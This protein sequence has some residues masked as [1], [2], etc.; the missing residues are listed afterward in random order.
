VTKG[1]A[2]DARAKRPRNPQGEG[3]RLRDELIAA[4]SRL[5]EAGIDPGDL[6]LRA[7][8]KEAR[9]AAPSIYLQ[10]ENKDSLMRAVVLDH[11]ARFRQ[12]LEAE[13]ARGDDPVSRLLYGCLAYGQFAR[14]Q[15]GSFRIIFETNNAEWGDP[16]PEE[17]IG[18]DTFMIL[19]NSVAECMEIGIARTGDPFQTAI[20]IWVSL[21]GMASLRQRM[22]NFPWP[23]PE[24][25]V[26]RVLVDL[27]GIP[28]TEMPL[29]DGALEES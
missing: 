20:D 2:I 28:T 17:P 27:T 23:T 8:A 13:V 19:V 15:P 11:F 16:H 10:F 22:P 7:V 4:A 14:E 5:L 21:H 26:A 1:Q 24:V 29:A 12:Q 9:V 18:L 3:R 25:Q 6:S